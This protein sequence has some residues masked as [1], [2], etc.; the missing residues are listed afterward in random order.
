MIEM[1]VESILNLDVLQMR[2][3]KIAQ[4]NKK[5]I[6]TI[7]DLVNFL[8]RKYYDF[9]YNSLYGRSCPSR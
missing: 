3:D 5:G 6:Y 8:P 2:N 7:E 1:E 4:F 9:T